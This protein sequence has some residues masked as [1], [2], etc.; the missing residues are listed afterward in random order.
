M[1]VGSPL[2]A[3]SSS[4]K[5]MKTLRQGRGFIRRREFILTFQLSKH[6]LE[7]FTFAAGSV[8]C[9]LT[10]MHSDYFYAADDALHSARKF[11][12][13][14]GADDDRKYAARHAHQAVLCALKGHAEIMGCQFPLAA[15]DLI[16]MLAIVFARDK[17]FLR[18]RGLAGEEDTILEIHRWASLSIYDNDPAPTKAQLL[19]AISICADL[20]ASDKS[21]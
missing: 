14:W 7:K 4:P 15:T 9:S 17:S 16:E 3:Q 20:I 18:D 10:D 1:T 5:R 6:P 2:K 11:T 19:A 8:S 13:F 21:T 12:H